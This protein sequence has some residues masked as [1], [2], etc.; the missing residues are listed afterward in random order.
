[1]AVDFNPNSALNTANGVFRKILLEAAQTT[2]KDRPAN[3]GPADVSGQAEVPQFGQD[4][5]L[6]PAKLEVKGPVKTLVVTKALEDLCE[7]R[8]KKFGFD[9][10][11]SF[12]SMLEERCKANLKIP[13][14]K[15]ELV[16]DVVRALLS[17]DA[18]AEVDAFASVKERLNVWKDRA[19]LLEVGEALVKLVAAGRLDASQVYAYANNRTCDMTEVEDMAGAA[20][21]CLKQMLDKVYGS[22]ILKLAKAKL[23]EPR[24]PDGRD[25]RLDIE[26]AIDRY[27]RK[28]E[29]ILPK[30][31]IATTHTWGRR[32]GK[33]L[34]TEELYLEAQA[35]KLTSW[36][37]GAY[38]KPP[39]LETLLKANV[40]L[41]EELGKILW[42][43]ATC[44]KEG[45]DLDVPKD[46]GRFI[47]KDLVNQVKVL[48]NQV[49]L[50]CEFAGDAEVRRKQELALTN[51]AQK[52]GGRI[53][54]QTYTINLG[55]SGGILFGTASKNIRIGGGYDY[56]M[57]IE[58]D[59]AGRV[60]VLGVKGPKGEIGFSVGFGQGK[61]LDLAGGL[62]GGKMSGTQLVY[63][64]VQDFLKNSST[65]LRI[66][67]NSSGIFHFGFDLNVLSRKVD[68]KSFSALLK[69][70][71][72]IASTDAFVPRR[73]AKT[74]TD[75]I[76][77][78]QLS[79]KAWGRTG[80]GSPVVAQSHADLEVGRVKMTK[81]TNTPI[82][83]NI[84]RA[85]LARCKA[86]VV[87]PRSNPPP[88]VGEVDQLVEEFD[89]FE[90]AVKYDAWEKSWRLRKR[91][92]RHTAFIQKPGKDIS[93]HV[94]DRLSLNAS[95]ITDDVKARFL[96]SIAAT[97]ASIRLDLEGEPGNGI[98]SEAKKAALEK[99]A[100]LQ[101]RV[102]Q[103]DFKIS[104]SSRRTHLFD[105]TETNL[106][107]TLKGSL[108]GAVKFN[109]HMPVAEV[110]GGDMLG[111]IAPGVKFRIDYHHRFNSDK[112]GLPH[113]DADS[114][115]ITIGTAGLKSESIVKSIVMA[116][117]NRLGKLDSTL[118]IGKS[119]LSAGASPLV[120]LVTGGIKK[121]AGK[122]IAPVDPDKRFKDT[123]F[124]L[125]L[126]QFGLHV[127]GDS[128]TGVRFRLSRT[129]EGG[130][131]LES[132]QAVDY[133][134][135]SVEGSFSGVAPVG[136]GGYVSV[137]GGYGSTHVMDE[138]L[139][140]NSLVSF[141]RVADEFA[142]HKPSP[143]QTLWRT[144][145][146]Y[147]QS[148]IR[149]LAKG[150]GDPNSTVSKELESYLTKAGK[151]DQGLA[152]RLAAAADGL[153]EAHGQSTEK[154]ACDV[155]VTEFLKTLM[156]IS[157][158]HLK[159]NPIGGEKGVR[160]IPKGGNDIPEEERQRYDQV[161]SD[162]R[163][164]VIED[165][166]N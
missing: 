115:D 72:V 111:S 76:K 137:S 5:S 129:A 143:K 16:R 117:Y 121:G 38:S 53:L 11:S 100:A 19:K 62:S 23:K 9:S 51:Y 146:S 30:D 64:N 141:M 140:G 2:L 145:L 96:A 22:E 25:A 4:D 67:L 50:A 88:L 110:L 154:G 87:R 104:R 31:I 164:I 85:G 52:H 74:V 107:R 127:G 130:W 54:P 83:K 56:K 69:K 92:N 142:L 163:K 33:R 152:E 6:A 63:D 71:G 98:D 60:A 147:N 18:A 84:S 156:E 108:D 102:L 28:L 81:L 161:L 7:A 78:D 148:G 166:N 118:A 24:R 135:L 13:S 44:L 34:E 106:G 95:K 157:E 155:P 10:F 66:R 139:Y 133:S 109:T 37:K 131:S 82:F 159:K 47:E 99:L 80:G 149:E 15:T 138:R 91:L 116:V 20:R 55:A 49:K 48:R 35:N 3:G 36:L 151:L 136:V 75:E 21:V 17:T 79:G 125:G 120:S 122:D 160:N 150:L 113:L 126:A 89:D 1:M 43:D 112:T 114:V 59:H 132:V 77:V 86:P 128:G 119:V 70:S 14:L 162:L 165:P 94:R 26:R 29:Q 123:K 73:P 61:G 158:L 42:N 144:F 39:A 40:A 58:V 41:A 134:A 93:A 153:K 68:N 103:P 27:E 124:D 101:E 65:D 105:T 12:V 97:A 8:A 57:T 90:Q 45:M 46:V 32:K